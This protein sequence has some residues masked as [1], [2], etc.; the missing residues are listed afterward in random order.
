MIWM[1]F[2]IGDLIPWDETHH[3]LTHHHFWDLF[4]M[5]R[6]FSSRK[7]KILRTNSNSPLDWRVFTADSAVKTP[8]LIL[9]ILILILL[10]QNL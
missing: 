6:T 4:I 9:V 5:F 7:S 1:C 8:I 10:I 2:F 3:F